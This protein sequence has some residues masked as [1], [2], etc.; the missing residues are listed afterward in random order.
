MSADD[1]GAGGLTGAA[2]EK[3]PAGETLV[4]HDDTPS[5]ALMMLLAAV[6]IVALLDAPSTRDVAMP[7][8]FRARVALHARAR[9]AGVG[10]RRA[11]IAARVRT[12]WGW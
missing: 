5:E 8:G 1:C 10:G 3:S 6:V 4:A 7:A 11:R 12:W 9:Q 2:G